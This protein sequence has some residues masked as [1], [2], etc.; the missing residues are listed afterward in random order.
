MSGKRGLFVRIHARLHDDE[1][2][3]SLLETVIAITIIFGSLITLAMSASTGF[4]YVAI[5]REEQAAN[6]IANQLMEQVRGLAFTKISQGLQTSDLSSDPNLVTTCTGD[7]TGTYRYGSCSGDKV[8]STNFDCPTLASDCS[9]PLVP[10]NGTIG[11]SDDYP[12]DY[13]WRTY[14]T[15]NCTSADGVCKDIDPY[16]VTVL[17]EWA[18]AGTAASGIQRVRTQSLFHSPN[19]CVSSETHPFSAPCQPFFYGQALAPVGRI[20]VSGSV[21]GVD[22][23][24]GVVTT[25]GADSTL[26]VEQVSSVQGGWTQSG[27]ELATS[28]GTSVLPEVLT[29]RSTAADSDPSGTTPSYSATTAGALGFSSNQFASGGSSFV[30]VQNAANDTGQAIS[31]TAAGGVNACPPVPPAPP[32]ETDLQ[33]CG[34]AFT[35]QA[36]TARV[37]G[38]FHGFASDVGDATI[39]SIGPPTLY[40]TT[41]ADRVPVSGFDGNVQA[42]ATRAYG[43]VA[44]GGLP[45]SVIVPIGWTGY[46]VQLTGYQDTVVSTAGTSAAVPTATINA[47]T[48]SYWNGLGYTSVNLTTTPT[49]SLSGLLL[50]H[51][52]LTSDLHTVRIKIA[53]DSLEME[54]VPTVTSTPS[55]SG[56]ILRN[57]TRAT[58]GSPMVGTFTYEMWLDG[59]QVVNFEIDVSMGTLTSKSIYQPAPSAGS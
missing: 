32:L 44:I 3:F 14:V 16:K 39:V 50:D 25:T 53:T 47:G 13:N 34:G 22:F 35:R 6:Q 52:T 45:E 48:L 20:S 33:P 37:V 36:G 54:S 55:G 38:H 30:Q 18:G 8:V 42:T 26:Q 12:V 5:G 58:V 31:A 19:G 2:G 29:S 9:T 21:S 56:S 46:F 1:R 40:T 51:T 4:R 28:T 23:S 15:N 17:V 24:S 43:T 49:Y 59:S 11:A 57:E 41:F 10:N 7:P 27:T